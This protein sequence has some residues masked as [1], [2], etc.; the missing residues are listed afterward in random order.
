[1]NRSLLLFVVAASLLLFSAGCTKYYPASAFLDLSIPAQQS[2]IYDGTLS[3]NIFGVDKRSTRELIRYQF[4]DDVRIPAADSLQDVVAESLAKGFAAQGLVVDEH[5][6]MDIGV[7][8]IGMNVKV[9]KD[10]WTY[11]A[12]ASTRLGVTVSKPQGV[13]TKKYARESTRMSFFRPEPRELEKM[14]SEEVSEL[15]AGVLQD[16]AIAEA[17][18][19]R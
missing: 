19:S 18:R 9:T 6:K 3:A 8:I 17:I 12:A 5:G 10:F 15:V 7:E 13:F 2:G 16:G 1:M 11:T 4:G 14:L